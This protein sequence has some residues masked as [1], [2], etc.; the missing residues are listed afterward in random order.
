MEEDV[1]Q[2]QQPL[3]DDQEA[4]QEIEPTENELLPQQPDSTPAP[5][6]V[7]GPAD[8]YQQA[9]P[10]PLY[11]PK[12]PKDRSLALILEII[13]AL[14]GLYGIGWIYS[15]NT[16]VGIAWLLGVLLWEVI[17]TVI[18]VL[19]GFLAC[20]CVVPINLALLAITAIS[21]NNYTKRHPELFGP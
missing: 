8:S 13:P 6:P 2:D 18:A 3:E 9:A 21:L 14:F 17:A 16:G 7:Q 4:P 15:G 11:A 5:Q 20:F 10:L 12:P 1:M 19:S